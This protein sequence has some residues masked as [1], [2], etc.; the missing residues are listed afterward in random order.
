MLPLKQLGRSYWGLHIPPPPGQWMFSSGM[1]TWIP[2]RWSLQASLKMLWLLLGPWGSQLSSLEFPHWVLPPNVWK[3]EKGK[4]AKLEE[5]SSS[6]CWSPISSWVSSPH[7]VEENV[8]Q[9]WAGQS[10]VLAD[11]TRWAAGNTEVVKESE[12]IWVRQAESLWARCKEPLP[13]LWVWSGRGRQRLV[14]ASCS[15][16]LSLKPMAPAQQHLA[17][18]CPSTFLPVFR[19]LRHEL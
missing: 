6:P 8:S 5:G 15:L 2:A 13:V 17:D 19:D 14:L 10:L 18:G 1:E 16:R 12:G 3:R 9:C 4:V 11:E 7:H